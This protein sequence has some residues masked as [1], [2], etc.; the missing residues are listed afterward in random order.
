MAKKAPKKKS[1]TAAE[2]TLSALRARVKMIERLEAT[3]KALRDALDEAKKAKPSKACTA[4][5]R[6]AQTAVASAVKAC[7]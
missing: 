6:R 2:R 4:A 1:K 7:S 3:Q 5:L